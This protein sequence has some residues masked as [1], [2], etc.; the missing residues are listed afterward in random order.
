MSDLPPE[1]RQMLEEARREAE[2]L[3]RAALRPG[4]DPYQRAGYRDLARSA[5]AEMSL[6]QKALTHQ[7]A[8]DQ[9]RPSA[10]TPGSAPP[11]GD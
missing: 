3:D 4:L 7:P 6:L 10:P 1:L 9:S 2:F 5:R 8:D 11:T